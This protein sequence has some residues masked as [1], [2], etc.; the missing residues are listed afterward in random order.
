MFCSIKSVS[1]YRRLSPRISLYRKPRRGRCFY[2][3]RKNSS[4]S[5]HL[6]VHLGS[7]P[8]YGPMITV[9]VSKGPISDSQSVIQA[10]STRWCVTTRFKH[11]K[12]CRHSFRLAFFTWFVFS[13]DMQQLIEF[14]HRDNVLL[15]FWSDMNITLWSSISKTEY[16]L[17]VDRWATNECINSM[18]DLLWLSDFGI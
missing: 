5:N 11:E 4:S 7:E 9:F 3:L 18:N 10:L 1:D 14:L 16:S 12:I 8:F 2:F 17:C 6:I 13:V 15:Q